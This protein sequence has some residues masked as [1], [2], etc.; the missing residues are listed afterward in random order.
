MNNDSQ[1]KNISLFNKGT[2][3]PSIKEEICYGNE[4]KSVRHV[5]P[6]SKVSLR[7]D[8]HRLLNMDNLEG[9]DLLF[10]KDKS[11]DGIHFG[12]FLAQLINNPTS[13]SNAS[14][15]HTCLY[16]GDGKIA[17]ASGKFACIRMVDLLEKPGKYDVLRFKDENIR[18]DLVR[19]AEK[20]VS[21]RKNDLNYGVYSFRGTGGLL[22]SSSYGKKA[23]RDFH[24]LLND[25]QFSKI[26]C[27]GF[28]GGIA[29]IVD[30]KRNDMEPSIVKIHTKHTSPSKLLKY[31]KSNSEIIR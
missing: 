12:I 26:H 6:N 13:W 29:Q 25:E 18:S 21:R 8:K 24:K 31:L 4:I 11:S 28:V 2:V 16:M 5:E 19:E 7:E 17:E 10:I 15:T 1:L 27:S 22:R 20:C 9:G 14:R 23:K 30:A 3:E